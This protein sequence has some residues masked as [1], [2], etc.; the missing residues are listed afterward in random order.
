LGG[1]SWV[2]AQPIIKYKQAPI[3]IKDTTLV[4]GRYENEVGVWYV[5]SFW[6]KCLTSLG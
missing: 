4:L 2:E 3:N 1:G 5:I 6:G